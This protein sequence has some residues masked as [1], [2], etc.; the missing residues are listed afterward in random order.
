[1]SRSFKTKQI[2]KEKKRTKK[3][4]KM[5]DIKSDKKSDKNSRINRS[6]LTDKPKKSKKEKRSKLEIEWDKDLKDFMRISHYYWSKRYP[7]FR[8]NYQGDK[9]IGY[10]ISKPYVKIPKQYYYLSRPA[11]L[12]PDLIL[13]LDQDQFVLKSVL[14]HQGNKVLLIVRSKVIGESTEYL[15]RD[16][17]RKRSEDTEKQMTLDELID[18]AHHKLNSPR[19]KG[20]DVPIIVEEFLGVYERDGIPP[21]FKV[22]TVAGKA[23]IIN[24]YK[25]KPGIKWEACFTRSWK[26]IPLHFFYRKIERLGYTEN[27]EHDS[28][29]LLPDLETRRKLIEAAERLAHIHQAK[30]CRYDFY[31]VEGEVY[32][33]EITPVCG[34]IKNMPLRLSALKHLFPQTLRSQLRTGKLNKFSIKRL[35]KHT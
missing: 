15:Y 23:R 4:S 3:I 22:Y 2:K 10:K 33:G 31:C 8:S 20:K 29:K 19:N 34:G 16:I 26:R 27:P 14:G 18:Y 32:L 11:K 28:N 30:F 25:R 7:R 9:L 5:K 13:K 6:D 17:F 35:V 1:M 21:D 24:I 12:T